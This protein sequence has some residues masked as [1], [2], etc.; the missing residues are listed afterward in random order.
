MRKPDSGLLKESEL[1][2]FADYYEYTS[3]KANFDHQ[4]NYRV[5]ENYFVR[6]IP[7]GS[8]L[9]SAGLEQVVA[10]I[11]IMMDGLNGENR[12]WLEK[13]SGRDFNEEFLDYMGDLHHD[14]DIY[15][16]PEGT[17]IFP[18][19]PIIN[20][21]GPS[22]DVQLFET[23]LLCV[24]NFESLI[25]TKASRMVNVAK[26]S[27]LIHEPPRKPLRPLRTL[28]D[29]GARRAHGRDAAIL[30]AR[31]SYIGGFDGTSLMI[32]GKKWN[33]PY[34]GT[35]PH[36]FIQERDPDEKEKDPERKAAREF[37]ES[38]FH[39]F[40]WLPDT[41]S[42]IPGIRKAIEIGVELREKGYPFKGLRLDSGD[43]LVLSKKARV[44]LDAEGFTDTK[45]FASSDLDEYKID[46]EGD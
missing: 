8:Y 44:M 41:Y 36:K 30:A 42:T 25:A 14:I 43:P 7:Q 1:I 22:I 24:G 46:Y 13:T 31:A 27:P 10:D 40:V 33:I 4:A 21:T 34:V 12:E 18:N 9:I 5:T 38:F 28:L 35:V 19:E 39:N 6:K 45:I 17:P 16:V 15:A 11:M 32:A 29:F 26:Y 37:S 20:I 23:D 2:L 3:G